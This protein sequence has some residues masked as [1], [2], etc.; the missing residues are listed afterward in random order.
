MWEFLG[1]LFNEVLEPTNQNLSFHGNKEVTAED[2]MHLILFE[3]A[4]ASYGEQVPNF[5]QEV[6]V[7]RDKVFLK[8]GIKAQWPGKDRLHEIRSFIRA[9]DP[10]EVAL[11]FEKVSRLFDVYNETSKNVI[12]GS[13]IMSADDC[14]AGYSGRN[15]IYNRQDRKPAKQGFLMNDICL[16]DA[17]YCS[18]LLLQK[19]CTFLKM[20]QADIVLELIDEIVT[21]PYTLICCDKGYT[22]LQIVSECTKKNIGYI[23]TIRPDWLQGDRP[24]FPDGKNKNF[25]KRM[26]T[27]KERSCDMFLTCFYDHA[28]KKPVCFLSNFHTGELSSNLTKRPKISSIYK[29]SMFAVDCFDFIARHYS[30]HHKTHKWTVRMFELMCGYL[31]INARSAYCI[32][33]NH[34]MTTYTMSHFYRDLLKERYTTVEVVHNFTFSPKGLTSRTR[35]NWQDCSGR[36][37]VPC[38]NFRCQKIAC[39]KVHSYLIC[40]E[41]S[42]KNITRLTIVKERRQVKHRQCRLYGC[43]N[44]TTLICSVYGCDMPVCDLHRT[45]LCYDCC[46]NTGTSSRHNFSLKMPKLRN[47]H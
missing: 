23:G 41:C 21:E 4:S 14:L 35:C 46:F 38:S 25:Q 45:K 29:R 43:K 22:T 44:R 12:S 24:L 15:P 10:D 27:F 13:N 36:S 20:G 32:S 33:N 9:Y 26:Y 31:L 19:E 37:R 47:A 30:I 39:E 1:P 16:I 8:L 28:G 6:S 18:K 40:L 17:R 2:L 34:D 5:E 11:P 42:K 3:V 7:V